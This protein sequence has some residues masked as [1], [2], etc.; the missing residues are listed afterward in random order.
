MYIHISALKITQNERKRYEASCRRNNAGNGDKVFVA[1]GA[2]F[3]LLYCVGKLYL[4][5]HNVDRRKKLSCM[6]STVF[7]TSDIVTSYQQVQ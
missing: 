7:S 1:C 4:S 3:K 2:L 5:K 6:K